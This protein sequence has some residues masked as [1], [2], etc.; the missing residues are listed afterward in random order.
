L[1]R[2]IRA[3]AG[4]TICHRKRFRSSSGSSAPEHDGPRSVISNFAHGPSAHARG[5]LPHPTSCRRQ[6]R[7]IR[8][9]AGTTKLNQAG[10]PAEV[11]VEAP[12]A[13]VVAPVAVEARA[14][15][16]AG[17]SAV[18]RSR[19]SRRAARARREG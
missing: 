12:V 18:A 3:R 1:P 6:F 2:S 4:A 15:A 16:S 5:R 9:R 19:A 14:D 13:S 10:A 17:A 8:A 11:S 7:S